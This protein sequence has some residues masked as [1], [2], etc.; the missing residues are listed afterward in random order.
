[1]TRSCEPRRVSRAAERER[2]PRNTGRPPRRHGTPARGLR[3]AGPPG[4]RGRRDA[5]RE[6]QP[7]GRGRAAR[8]GRRN[9]AAPRRRPP[10]SAAPGPRSRS[11]RAP[12]GTRLPQPGAQLRRAGQANERRGQGGGSGG[13]NQEPVDAIGHHLG[14]AAD[15]GGDHRNAPRHGL[16]Q[17]DAL[18]LAQGGEDRHRELGGQRGDVLATAGEDDARG[19]RRRHGVH[20]PAELTL[21][22]SPRPRSRGGPRG[23]PRRRPAT[24][25]AGGRAP[26]PARAA[27]RRP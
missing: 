26:S 20:Q 2:P 12:C 18:G 7:Q 21:P 22:P 25:R 27:R 11:G 8:R 9:A 17:R 10:R 3:R 5:R 19:G 23:R 4:W 1:M 13:G 6:S 15:G 24:P 14:N 16:Q